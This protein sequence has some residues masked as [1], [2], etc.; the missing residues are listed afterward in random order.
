VLAAN[1]GDEAGH[2]LVFRQ[3]LRAEADH[4]DLFADLDEGQAVGIDAG[5]G[6]DEDLHLAAAVVDV[7]L[8]AVGNVVENPGDLAFDLDQQALGGLAD[9]AGVLAVGHEKPD[10]VPAVD[11][12]QRGRL[13]Y[14]LAEAVIRQL[15][16]DPGAVADGEDR[17]V[18]GRHVDAAG[19]VLQ[20]ETLVESR[21]GVRPGVGGDAAFDG[22]DGAQRQGA[23]RGDRE[24]RGGGRSGEEQDCEDEDSKMG[25]DCLL[26]TKRWIDPA[27]FRSLNENTDR[28][29]SRRKFPETLPY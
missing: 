25:H 3:E 11:V 2:H 24:G 12:R 10:A 20:G 21:G 5:G 13:D 6:G 19:V 4:F 28:G 14:Q 23:R 26:A 1:V 17:I 15:A 7:D 22:H 9:I 29:A 27:V 8:V 18:R 16:G